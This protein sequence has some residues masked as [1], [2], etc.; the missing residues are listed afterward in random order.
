MLSISQSSNPVKSSSTS[1]SFKSTNMPFNISLSHSPIR[2]FWFR[3]M[4]N[5]FSTVSSS[6]FKSKLSNTQPISPN[7]IRY[8]S[9][10]V[11]CSS[12][13]ALYLWCPPM[14]VFSF[15]RLMTIGS[16]SPYWFKD[17]FNLS[18]FSSV[19]VLGL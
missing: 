14:M 8:N 15:F 11:L 5:N 10:L 4:F 17:C 12:N 1:L 18:K 19:I 13:N 7:L 16:T 3:L 9:V 6:T 2:L